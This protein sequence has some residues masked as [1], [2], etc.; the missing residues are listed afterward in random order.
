MSSS[1]T[2]G[3]S[4][5]KIRNRC[6]RGL[7]R[8]IVLH[9][10]TQGPVYGWELR[11]VVQATGSTISMGS[12]Y[13]LL[14]ALEREGLL[15]GTANR[16]TGRER[17]YYRLTAKGRGTYRQILN[18]VAPVLRELFFDPPPDAH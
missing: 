13:P 16:A 9:R 3:H 6:V 12:F 14:N 7:V 5:E 8:L 15:R 1:R 17:K 18:E 11:K 10:A 4:S 2:A